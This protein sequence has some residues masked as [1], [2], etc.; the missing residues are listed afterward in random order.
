M[1]ELIHCCPAEHCNPTECVLHALRQ[2]SYP[3]RIAW[4]SAL[5]KDDLEFL[6]AYH[7]VCMKLRLQSG[8]EKFA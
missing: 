5:T 6:A 4:Y 8:H 1:M 3:Q 2:L 7:H